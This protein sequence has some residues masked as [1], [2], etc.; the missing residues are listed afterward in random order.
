MDVIGVKPRAAQSH[1]PAAVEAPA[2]VISTA[3]GIGAVADVLEIAADGGG[4]GAEQRADR[5]VGAARQIGSGL[6]AMAQRLKQQRMATGV[7]QAVE[8]RPDFGQKARQIAPRW[9]RL[10]LERQHQI[11]VVAQLCVALI[12]E[13][14]PPGCLQRDEILVIWRDRKSTRL[15]S[16]HLVISYAVFCLKKK[17]HST[18]PS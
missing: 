11:A 6:G 4:K 17:N 9:R 18:T 7:V 3:Q 14:A 8:T 10:E 5:G 13:Q 12:A 15:N 2:A 1:R 16:S